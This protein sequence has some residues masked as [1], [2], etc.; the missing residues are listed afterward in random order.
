[1]TLITTATGVRRRRDR[2]DGIRFRLANIASKPGFHLAD[3][4]VAVF[5]E[6]FRKIRL[7]PSAAASAPRAQTVPMLHEIRKIYQSDWCFARHGRHCGR[8][9][10]SIQSHADSTRHMEN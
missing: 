9:I 6:Q 3:R 7:P 4:A 2:L 1:M 5:V 8:A 10:P